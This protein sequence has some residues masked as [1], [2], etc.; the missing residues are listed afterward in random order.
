MIMMRAWGD[1][2]S[3]LLLEDAMTTAVAEIQR[4][5]KRE[6]RWSRVSAEESVSYAIGQR[7][8]VRRPAI[9]MRAGEGVER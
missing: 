1:E 6:G 7:V 2:G 5:C 8:T 3:A 9:S 4:S